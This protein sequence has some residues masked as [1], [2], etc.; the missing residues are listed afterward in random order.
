M[1]EWIKALVTQRIEDDKCV[2]CG[3]LAS[4]CPRQ[5]KLYEMIVCEDCMCKDAIAIEIE[6]KLYGYYNKQLFVQKE[7]PNV[8]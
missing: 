4:D 5:V 1:S 7:D 3:K 6:G 8:N 2:S